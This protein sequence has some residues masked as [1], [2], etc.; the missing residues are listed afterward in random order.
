MRKTTP[1][2][3][4]ELLNEFFQKDPTASYRMA[5]ARVALVW[6]ALVGRTIASHTTSIKVE[7]GV[8]YVRISSSVARNEI[9]MRREE[10]KD[11][12]NTA[13]GMRVVNV[14]IVK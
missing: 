7:K 6:E 10:L 14:V 11:A 8:M 13:V 9:F 12:V 5:E 1:L 4:G 2:S 3:V